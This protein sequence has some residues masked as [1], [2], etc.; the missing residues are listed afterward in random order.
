MSCGCSKCSCAE[1]GREQDLIRNKL[2]KM[3]ALFKSKQNNLVTTEQNTLV[4][5]SNDE[6]IALGEQVA[7]V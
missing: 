2:V 4:T 6:T 7:G 3:Q 1:F 5:E